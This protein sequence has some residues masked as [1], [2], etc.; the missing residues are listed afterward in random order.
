MTWLKVASGI[1]SVSLLSA[2]PAAMAQVFPNQA[3]AN[4]NFIPL[5]IN[6]G[7]I[8]YHQVYAAAQFGTDPVEIRSLGFAPN[9]GVN[10]QTVVYSELV[11]S[12]GYTDRSPGGLSANLPDNPPRKSHAGTQR[13]GLLAAT[14]VRRNRGLLAGLPVRHAMVLQPE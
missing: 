8:T 5:G 10:G 9:P 3:H 4:Y 1:I 2:A 7:P 14:S 13:A 6:N 12:L 11:I